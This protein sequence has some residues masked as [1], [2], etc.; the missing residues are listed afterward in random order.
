M[1]TRADGDAWIVL[2]A[3]DGAYG[4]APGHVFRWSDS[5]CARMVQGLGPRVAP[6][7]QEVP[8]YRDAPIVRYIPIGAYVGAPLL[9][10]DG[11][12]F[13]TLCAVDPRARPSALVDEE[14]LVNLLAGLLG[15]ILENDLRIE[16]AARRAEQAESDTLIDQLTGVGNDRL[17]GRVLVAEETRC[18]RYGSAASIIWVGLDDLR[19]VNQARGPF[20]GD[21]V[22]RRTARILCAA[23]RSHDVVAR[24]GGDEFGVLAVECNPASAVTLVHRLTAGLSEA[25]IAA[26]IGVATRDPGAGGLERACCEAREQMYRVR[27]HKKH[28][29]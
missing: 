24:I 5:L 11:T 13:G 12:L 27:Q 17:W 7:V 26:S 3:T 22:I 14:P 28:R 16:G 8:A 29:K 10:A 19:E 1:V 18:S 25:S 9:R 6:V 4:V 15:G 21:E 2:H 20:A 23:G